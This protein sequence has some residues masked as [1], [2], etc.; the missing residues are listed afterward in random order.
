MYHFK[1][2]QVKFTPEWLKEKND[3]ADFLSIM[4]GWWFEGKFKAK[5]SYVEC[6]TYKF[7]KSIQIIVILL[8]RV[9]KR[10]VSS[11]FRDK[12]ILIIH[13]VI[14]H[15]STLNWGVSSSLDL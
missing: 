9:F 7:K 6:K 1:E 13:Q 4:K 15:A 5:P 3:Y 2:S 11:S 12:W 10:K 14:T 8:S